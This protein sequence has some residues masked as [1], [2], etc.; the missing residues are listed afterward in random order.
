MLGKDCGIFGKY[1]IFCKLS[2]NCWYYNI[3]WRQFRSEMPYIVSQWMLFL[4]LSDDDSVVKVATSEIRR[5][6]DDNEA[7]PVIMDKEFLSGLWSSWGWYHS[8]CE[9]FRWRFGTV[10]RPSCRLYHTIAS[11]IL[12]FLR[13]FKHCHEYTHIPLLIIRLYKSKTTFFHIRSTL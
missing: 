7:V 13:V 8:G 11:Y 9:M 10:R 5:W 2:A 1:L 12:L 3:K 4:V 6:Y